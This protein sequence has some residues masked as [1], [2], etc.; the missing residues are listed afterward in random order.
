M[1][2]PAV[3]RPRPQPTTVSRPFWEAT[4]RGEFLLQRCSR[5]GAHVFYPR[6]SCT[7][8]GSPEL[9]WR[10][11]RGTGTL[12]TYTVA[13]RPTHPAFAGRVPYVLAV[14]ELDEGPHVTTELVDCDPDSVRIGM[15]VEVVFE[16]P[17]DGIALPLFRPRAEH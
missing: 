15:P 16:D 11:A 8:C 7:D 2:R 10:P 5:C 9:E 12:Y 3:P 6:Y 4:A 13:R 17:V 14:V 1:T